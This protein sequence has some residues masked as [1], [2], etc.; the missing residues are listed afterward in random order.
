MA[1]LST[2]RTSPGATSDEKAISSLKGLTV[3]RV[4]VSEDGCEC[5]A[6]IGVRI[7]WSPATS[8]EWA[9]QKGRES[10][11]VAIDG[12]PRRTQAGVTARLL[13]LVAR[14]HLNGAYRVIVPVA[15]ALV[16]GPLGAVAGGYLGGKKD[17][18]TFICK[19]N[20]GKQ[21]VGIM[22]KSMFVALYA[23]FLLNPSPE[24]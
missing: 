21:F 7:Y 20:D 23:P 14:N 13:A 15:G 17:E 12:P 16:A 9:L 22:K 5:G 24:G 19:L 6:E 11:L 3:E 2:S 18:I 1:G 10:R 4:I 8:T